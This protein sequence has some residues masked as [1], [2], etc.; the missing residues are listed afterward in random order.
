MEKDK[1]VVKQDDTEVYIPRL[2]DYE[3][4][5]RIC[6]DLENY[7][8]VFATIARYGR[9]YFDKIVPTA[10]VMFN[11]DGD[12]IRFVFNPDFWKRIDHYSKL[13]VIC[14]ECLHIIGNHGIRLQ[15]MNAMGFGPDLK[16]VSLGN[17]ATDITINE[18]LL[19]GFNFDRNFYFENSHIE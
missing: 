12:L 3:D 8:G 10:A 17:I 6:F 9:F 15:H 13:W 18:L 11:K 2:I 1:T 19:S 7:H 14:H 16:P 4:Y 5:Q